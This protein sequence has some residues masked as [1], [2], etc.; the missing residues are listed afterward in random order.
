MLALRRP[1]SSA[2]HES[3][4]PAALPHTLS[5]LVVPRTGPEIGGTTPWGNNNP[6][7]LF[8][9]ARFACHRTSSPGTLGVRARPIPFPGPSAR[10]PP[11]PHQGLFLPANSDASNN[12]R[13]RC[14]LPLSASN[15]PSAT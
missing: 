12:L 9:V 14:L 13:G 7:T 2:S 3:S 10:A 4:T 6:N 1:K 15:T 5:Y 11:S 8:R